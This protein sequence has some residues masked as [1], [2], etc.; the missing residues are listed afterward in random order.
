MVHKPLN[1]GGLCTGYDL[2]VV[3][4]SGFQKAIAHVSKWY[5]LFAADRAYLARLTDCFADPVWDRV[6]ASAVKHDICPVYGIYDDL[7][8]DAVDAR[9]F[10]AAAARGSDPY[11]E[12]NK[13][14]RDKKL[15][16]AN[17]ADELAAYFKS[18]ERY[19]GIADYYRRFLKPIEEL[20]AFHKEEARVLRQHAGREPVP[21]L[22]RNRRGIGNR[23]RQTREQVAF[24]SFF[25]DR[26]MELCG[27]PHYDAVAAITNATFPKADVT[28]DNVRSARRPTT[29]SG[30]RAKR[31][32]T[33]KN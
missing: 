2:G 32:T 9:R 18:S 15:K 28:A 6:H 22:P 27:Q 13:E 20:Q 14:L 29:R 12:H 31:S 21:S 33:A 16:M 8:L 3:M 23:G 26:L 30:R 25:A 17:M 5:K 24:M 1:F 10:A 11:F 19:S 4:L 7:V